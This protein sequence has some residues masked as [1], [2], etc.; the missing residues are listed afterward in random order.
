MLEDF[1]VAAH[2]VTVSG[3][4]LGDYLLHGSPHDSRRENTIGRTT[5][6]D[7]SSN[8]LPVVDWAARAERDLALYGLEA[9][10]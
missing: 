2:R 3:T 6:S 5:R 7:R 4:K 9:R 8:V 10:L 1:K